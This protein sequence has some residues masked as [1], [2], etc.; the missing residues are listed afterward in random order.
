M[1]LLLAESSNNQGSRPHSLW[2]AQGDFLRRRMAVQVLT[3]FALLSCWGLAQTGSPQDKSE[4]VRLTQDGQQWVEATLRGL[5]LEEKVGQMLQVRSYAEYPNFE[6]ADYKWLQERVQKDH[7]G[8]MILAAHINAQGL[9]RVDPLAAAKTINQLQSDAKLPLLM[10]ADLE[11]GVASRLEN[12]PDFPWPMA[13]GAVD[14]PATAE[15]VG[16]ITARAARAVG[17]NWALAPVADVNSNPANPIIND[18]S[19]G[20][21][22]ARVGALVAAFI[23]GAR[24]HGLL[25]TAKHFPGY[26]DA[27]IDS[28]RAIASVDAT[29]DHLQTVEFPP[30]R[31]A[32]EAGVDAILLVHARVPALEPD[33]EKITT[34]SAKI[35]TDVLKGQLAFQGVVLTDALEMRGVTGL[36]DPRKGDPAAQAAVDAVK[37]GCDVIMTPMDVDAPFQAIVQAV[38]SGEIPESR[39]DESVRKVLR[40]K[41]AV[42]LDR[43]RTVDLEQVAALTGKPEDKEFAQQVADEA[44]TLVRHNGQMLPLPKTGTPAENGPTPG[45]GSPA[46]PEWV[47]IVLG[48]GLEGTNGREFEKAWRSRRP[49]APVFY[50]DNRSPQTAAADILSAVGKAEGVVVAAYVAHNQARQVMSNGKTS[51]SFGLLG[52]SGQLLQRVLE[53]ATDK[54]VVVAFGSPYLIESFPNIQ[55][56]ICAYAMASTSEISAVKALFGEV[57][58]HAKLPVTLPGVA[59]RGFSLPWPA[60]VTQRGSQHQ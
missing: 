38:R 31:K 8:S 54:T 41:A 42:G 51:T 49:N 4:P 7:I 43:T 6:T 29:M 22:P 10:A 5:S 50:F 16:A 19:F 11:R 1:T 3:A 25:V 9:V 46:K 36:Y 14:D 2:R 28:H 18:R 47:A 21:D 45:Q 35:V 32:I 30:F 56:Y 24:A 17:I 53:A 58:N 57:Q 39:I 26:G 20:E 27:A 48:Q 15:R 40:M 59:E 55:T 52:P 44:V 33:S 37:A 23:R 13:L 12:V 34:N 60:Q